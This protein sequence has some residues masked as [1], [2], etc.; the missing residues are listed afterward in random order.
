MRDRHE[1]LLRRRLMPLVAKYSAIFQERPLVDVQNWQSLADG[2][3][4]FAIRYF[5][6]PERNSQ[7][8]ITDRS[9]PS[10][11]SAGAW[12]LRVKKAEVGQG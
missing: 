3:I 2:N 4:Q 6:I 7:P 8:S 10:R 9:K 11:V 12:P 5:I 1:Q